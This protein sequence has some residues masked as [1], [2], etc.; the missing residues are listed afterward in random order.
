MPQTSGAQA[1]RALSTERDENI[2]L[3]IAGDRGGTQ[4]NQI[5]IPREFA[6][7][8]EALRAREFRDAFTLAP[9]ILAATRQ[10]VVEAY[11]H[12]PVII[13]FAGHGD[14]RSLSF[15]LLDDQGVVVTETQVFADQLSAILRNF[16]RPVRLCVLNTCNSASIAQHLVD[17]GVVEAAIGWPGMLAD[18][19]AIAFSKAFYGCI[20]NGLTLAQAIGLAAESS[21]IGDA[22]LLC[23]AGNASVNFTN[24]SAESR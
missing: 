18:A 12:R 14:Q 13:H 22:P 23:Q 4:R 20:G 9:P 17:A 1:S 16:P 6:S 7:M 24:V 11:K 10:T 15:I 8:D 21:G 5:Q 3:F 19:T 2:V